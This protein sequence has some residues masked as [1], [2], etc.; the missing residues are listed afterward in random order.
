MTG[1]IDEAGKRIGTYAY[2]AGGRATGS[3][4]AGGVNSYSITHQVPPVWS[5]TET[6]DSALNVIWRDHVLKAPT[7]TQL[8]GPD[9][10]V[11]AIQSADVQ[12]MPRVTA[13]SQPAGSGCGP[14]SSS[15]EYDANANVIRR[16]DFSGMRTCYAYDL[17]R[18]LE[19]SRVEGLANTQACSAATPANAALPA[20]SRKISTAWH[21]DWR[22]AIKVAEPRR[23]TTY[24]YNGQPDPFAS[25]AIA[26][27]A[28]S[29][30][31]L[32][33]GKPI[34]V[35]CKTVEQATDDASGGSGFAAVLDT[36]VPNRVWTYTYNEF[37]QV[38]T[39]RDPRGNTT[40]NS[41]YTTTTADYTRGD[42]EKST[43][44]LSQATR[45][46]KYNPM[47]QVLQS[48]DA[49]NVVTDYQYDLRGRLTRQTTG[50]Q[51]T[52][53]DYWPTG[54][55]K[56]VTQPDTSYV[57]YEYDPA[58][59]L[60]AVA[61]NLGNRIEYTLDNSGNRREERI[62]DPT[63]VLKRQVGRVFDALGRAQQVTGRE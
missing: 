45:F 37:G 13:Q 35:L 59:R 53:Y 46:T 27:C 33:D 62:K 43:N 14:A 44:A 47:G 25:N 23:L 10:K 48:I 11:A 51:S 54:Q 61:D 49:N 4:G 30:A 9:G 38:L 16:D 58:Q 60:V 12:N 15:Q 40:T 19:T 1:Q 20:G 18:N 41:Y 26:N 34:A 17:A 21:P 7:G 22:M 55:L 56:R 32:P 2:D 57:A 8:V 31:K 28:P 5:V 63:G 29:T 24:V 39:S 36:S 52:V 50:G 42:L 6:Y 3:Q